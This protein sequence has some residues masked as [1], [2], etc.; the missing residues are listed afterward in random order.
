MTPGCTVGYLDVRRMD[1]SA[2]GTSNVIGLATGYPDGALDDPRVGLDGIV[3][4][5]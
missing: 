1:G 4:I 3:A 2:D 5:L